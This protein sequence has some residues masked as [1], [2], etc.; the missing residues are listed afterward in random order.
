M[1]ADSV[2][3]S[4][5]LRVRPSRVYFSRSRF[6]CRYVDRRWVILNSFPFT[7]REKRK[8]RLEDCQWSHLQIWNV[9]S[10]SAEDDAVKMAVLPS[11]A[12]GVGERM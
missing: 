5:E 7:R 3:A 4:P 1:T 9:R 2:R 8:L 10:K 12:G 6:L 11:V